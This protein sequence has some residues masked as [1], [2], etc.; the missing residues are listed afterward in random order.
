MQVGKSDNSYCYQL[1]GIALEDVA[2]EKDLGI[3]INS[4]LKVSNQCSQAYAKAS[5]MLGVI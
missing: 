1:Q 4:D 3:I 2:E 5:K